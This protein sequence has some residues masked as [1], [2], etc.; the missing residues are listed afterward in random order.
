MLTFDH[1]FEVAFERRDSKSSDHLGESRLPKRLVKPGKI[2]LGLFQR[3]TNSEADKLQG[4]D[5]IDPVG[6]TKQGL[7][8]SVLALP[9]YWPAHSVAPRPTSPDR[10]FRQS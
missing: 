1:I 7:S 4:L 3:V 9:N 6:V 8:Q 2:S 5:A 10:V